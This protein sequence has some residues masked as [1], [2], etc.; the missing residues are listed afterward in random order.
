MP[1]ASGIADLYAI[2]YTNT[3]YITT[4]IPVNTLTSSDL[5]ATAGILCCAGGSGYSDLAA[6]AAVIANA[7]L[8][9]V[10]LGFTAVS[11]L[12][13]TANKAC[14]VLD[15]MSI[16]ITPEIRTYR[17]GALTVD[18]LYVSIVPE[19]YLE[20]SAT[21]VTVPAYHELGATA[22][23]VRP[24]TFRKPG[25]KYDGDASPPTITRDDSIY[26]EI[27]YVDLK[28]PGIR[29]TV[30]L[31]F[32]GGDREFYYKSLTNTVGRLSEN[33]WKLKVY[34]YEKTEDFADMKKYKETTIN[35]LHGY[36]DVDSA[37]KNAIDVVTASYITTLTAEATTIG[38]S[39]PLYAMA[40]T[41]S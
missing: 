11:G 34:S 27:E 4:T 13:A 15:V 38:V 8:P 25:I 7:D 35:G 20:L 41:I 14:F 31:T 6:S 36:T 33:K 28:Q 16:D 5:Y 23:T 3:A 30:R 22:T 40:V 24:A 39:F 19:R 29:K 12:S 17:T 37:I 26:S 18:S 21:A 32:A 10:V 9:A 2:A 1:V